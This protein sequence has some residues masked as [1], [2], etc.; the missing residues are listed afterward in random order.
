MSF[1]EGV[2]SPVTVMGGS[3][4]GSWPFFPSILSPPQ[5]AVAVDGVV[6]RKCDTLDQPA[7]GEQRTFDS[8]EEDFWAQEASAR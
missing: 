1:L 8:L 2:P 3:A 4:D 6:D 7:Q 5:A